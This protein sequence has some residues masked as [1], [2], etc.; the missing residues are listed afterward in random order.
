MT[1]QPPML[2]ARKLTKY[3]SGL[4]A[5]HDVDFVIRR[6]E[7]LGYLGPN[8]AGKS[9]TVKMLAGLLEPTSGEA[10]YQ[11]ENI[12]NNLKAYKSRM[13]YVPEESN[14]YAYL[15]G[16]E[17]VDLAGTLRGIPKRELD[18]RA[19]NLFNEFSLHPH[20]HNAIA[21]YSKG[22]RQRVMLISALLHDP[23]VLILDEPFSGLDVSF[24]L[25]LRRL[26]RM[27]AEQGKAIFFCSH[28][29]E[30]VEKVCTHLVVL[31]KGT[32]IAHGSIEEVRSSTALEDK[33]LEL[34][35]DVDAEQVAENII[36]AI[37]TKV[38]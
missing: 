4:P 23:D 15:S 30:V 19:A 28:V 1:T 20:R 11:G 38:S 6:G 33:F 37:R 14:L 7:V 8:G 24:A 36:A 21:S 34:T 17:Y 35:E 27:L 29:L 3:Y 25:V 10:L 22:M 12:N 26:I 31:R 13:G 32:V 18:E 16:W 5:V 2:E 9:T